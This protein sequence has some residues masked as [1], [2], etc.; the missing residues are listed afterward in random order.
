EV[1]NRG[2]FRY[3]WQKLLSP[4]QK[5][6][7]YKEAMEVWA[8]DALQYHDL[9]RDQRVTLEELAYN[10]L[11]W[12]VIQSRSH[13]LRSIRD[14]Q[15]SSWVQTALKIEKEYLQKYFC[16]DAAAC[17]ELEELDRYGK[18]LSSSKKASKAAYQ[19]IQSMMSGE[20]GDEVLTMVDRASG[21]H[22]ARKVS[23]LRSEL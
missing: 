12:N 9:D 3:N 5:E 16:E 13:R 11:H 20:E 8:E 18:H 4:E 21:S 22:E 14:R 17:P 15:P 1:L 23:E 19:R 6:E 2:D 10:F 7:L